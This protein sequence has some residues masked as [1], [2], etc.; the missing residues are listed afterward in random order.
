MLA[1][2]STARICRRKRLAEAITRDVMAI[3]ECEEAAVSI[4]FEDIVPERWKDDV[5]LPDIQ[6]CAGIIYK[7]PGYHL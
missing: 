4:A 5:Y 1:I 7:K 6:G 2:I 3:L